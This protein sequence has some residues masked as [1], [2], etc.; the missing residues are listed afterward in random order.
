MRDLMTFSQEL[1]ELSVMQLVNLTTHQLHE[2]DLHLQQL[3][4]WS[5]KTRL[6]LDTALEQ[7]YGERAR[8]ILLDSGR[9]TGT[10]HWIDEDVR[11]QFELPKRVNWDQKKLS[12]MAQRITHSG[13]RVE[14]YID[15][16]LSVS[17]TRFNHWPESLKA[18]FAPARTVKTGRAKFTLTLIDE[19]GV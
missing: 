7:R 17:E 12:E 18:Q 10:T 13:E 9:D 5:K 11:I 14:D 1:N 4:D 8:K 19:G 2:I 16:E 6:K 3:I 15:I